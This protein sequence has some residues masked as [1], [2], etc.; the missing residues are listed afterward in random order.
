MQLDHFIKSIDRKEVLCGGR[1]KLVLPRK[2]SQT[3][4]IVLGIGI[5]R[6]DE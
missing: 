2:S 4:N 1:K 5:V 6:C 3:I